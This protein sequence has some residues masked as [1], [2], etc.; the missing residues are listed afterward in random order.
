MRPVCHPDGWPGH[1]RHGDDKQQG[2]SFARTWKPEGRDSSL[3]SPTEGTSSR[4]IPG[5][6]G[7]PMLIPPSPPKTQ[8]P[9]QMMRFGAFIGAVVELGGGAI[10]QSYRKCRFSAS[11]TP[12]DVTVPGTRLS[13]WAADRCAG[14]R[15]QGLWY[16]GVPGCACLFLAW[17]EPRI[18]STVLATPFALAPSALVQSRPAPPIPCVACG[19]SST[20]A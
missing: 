4:Y 18:T 17:T 2:E 12:N 3:E 1:G 16:L 13:H 20:A 19:L 10:A 11:Q 9:S 7:M 5:T 14:V 6:A 8:E 15:R